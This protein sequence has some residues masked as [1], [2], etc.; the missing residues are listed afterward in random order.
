LN[1]NRHAGFELDSRM[2]H[3]VWLAGYHGIIQH[4]AGAYAVDG[5]IILS[6]F[7]ITLLYNPYLWRH[8][9]QDGR[10]NRSAPIR[11]NTLSPILSASTRRQ[12]VA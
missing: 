3:V 11:R 7:V 9:G 12:F 2:L 1:R 6:G 5:F 8:S 4:D 10:E